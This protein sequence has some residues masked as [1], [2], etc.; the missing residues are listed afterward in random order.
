[1]QRA[2]RLDLIPPYL[3][4]EIAR[5]KK[6][7][8]AAGRDLIDLGIGDPDQPTP[9]VIVDK[10]Y[11]VAKNP[12]THRYDESNAGDPTFLEAAAQWFHK[13]FGV[14]LD[15]ENELLLLIG[16]QRRLGAPVLGIRRSRRLYAR[17]R[18]ELYRAE[19]EYP[20][21]RRNALRDAPSCG[22]PLFARF[23]PRYRPMSHVLRK[24]YF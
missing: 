15:P 22:K 7:A 24:S 2:K 5:A 19:G 23:E 11:E 18:P 20:A 4:G 3:F 8:L 21:R 12:E 1:M 16:S 13:R 9:S 17:S 10:L 6:A 14:A